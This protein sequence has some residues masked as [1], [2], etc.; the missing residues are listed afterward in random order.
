MVSEKP[1]SKSDKLCQLLESRKKHSNIKALL[2]EFD[3]T[4]CSINEDWQEWLH[5]T[6]YM[7]LKESPSPILYACFSVADVYKPLVSKLY[8]IAFI[9]VWKNLKDLDKERIITD[10]INAINNVGAN[11]PV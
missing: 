1:T 3:T 11:A 8:N 9:S 7:L 5:K 10:F 6:S 4:K 2:K